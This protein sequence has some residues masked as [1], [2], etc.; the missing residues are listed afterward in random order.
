MNIHELVDTYTLRLS[1]MLLRKK[2]FYE[3]VDTVYIGEHVNNTHI[4]THISLEPGEHSVEISSLAGRLTGYY[5]VHRMVGMDAPTLVY[6][7]G[8]GEYPCYSSFM[9]ILSPLQCYN[10]VGICAPFSHK[11]GGYFRGGRS[12]H[13]YTAV[14]ASSV[15]MVQAITQLLK[16]RGYTVFVSGISLGGFV[17]AFH[18]VWFS[19]ADGYIPLMGGLYL[20]SALVDSAYRY[21]VSPVDAKTVKNVLNVKDV[22][23]HMDNVY[24]LFATYDKVVVPSVQSVPFAENSISYIPRGHITG[25]LSYALLRR[26]ITG[27]VEKAWKGGI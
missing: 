6:H 14:L 12:L 24:P 11:R 22:P 5:R 9:R 16:E 3:G 17:S 21:L 8:S 26:H 2:L 18:K 10:L 15:V 7:H 13:L 4:A 23:D 25:S 19:T 1:G 20:G 27:V